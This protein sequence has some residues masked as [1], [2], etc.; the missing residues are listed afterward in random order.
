MTSHLEYP[1]PPLSHLGQQ[2]WLALDKEY[3][4]IGLRPLLLSPVAEFF[5]ARAGSLAREGGG[6]VR[7]TDKHDIE[8][9]ILMLAALRPTDWG[10][11]QADHVLKLALPGGLQFN[12]YYNYNITTPYQDM[13]TTSTVCFVCQLSLVIVYLNY[14]LGKSF[15]IHPFRF[16]VNR[17]QVLL[18]KGRKHTLSRFPGLVK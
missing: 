18:C 6:R 1:A 8:T 16:T 12:P 5:L 2:L 14:R 11:K 3:S 9:L 4:D 17:L 15:C 13:F 7:Q 10:R